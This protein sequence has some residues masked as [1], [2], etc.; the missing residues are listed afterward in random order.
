MEVHKAYR[1][2]SIL[3]VVFLFFM[4]V[5]IFSILFSIA[6]LS[7]WYAPLL[8]TVLGLIQWIVS[9]YIVKK[10]S[11]LRFIKPDEHPMLQNIVTNLSK[12]IGVPRPCIAVI[13]KSTANAFVFGRTR[14]SSVLA[15]HEGLLETLDEAQIQAVI[16]HELSHI[17]NADSIL[18]TFISAIPLALYFLAESLFHSANEGSSGGGLTATVFMIGMYS[19]GCAFYILYFIAYVSCMWVSRMRE[20]IA[21]NDAARYAGADS[22]QSALARISYNLCLSKVDDKEIGIRAFCIEDPILV[23]KNLKRM[24]GDWEKFDLNRDGKL[25][26]RERRIAAYALFD[27]NRD[28]QIS[29]REVKSV[30]KYKVGGIIS[31]LSELQS[32]HPPTYKRIHALD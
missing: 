7:L 23:Q 10:L 24:L 31:R 20:Y 29:D 15:V 30:M 17:K 4:G 8:I 28:G 25:D 9:P 3:S 18:M 21:D 27:L 5:V 14:G 32:T 22:M 12:E 16:A 13:A 19:I 11:D 2:S 6:G 26:E 1:I